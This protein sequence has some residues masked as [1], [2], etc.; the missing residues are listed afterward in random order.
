MSADLISWIHMGTYSG[1]NFFNIYLLPIL[2]R[3]VSL[4]IFDKFSFQL[5][6]NNYILNDTRLCHWCVKKCIFIISINYSFV[7][8][9]WALFYQYQHSMCEIIYTR[10]CLHHWTLVLL[11][12]LSICTR[13]H[14]RILLMLNEYNV[15]FLL[16]TSS[17]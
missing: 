4:Y 3:S 17:P 5:T 11:L 2:K 1:Y 6:P 16:K 14:L 9:H 8:I 15:L 10:S 13:T 12:L 7:I